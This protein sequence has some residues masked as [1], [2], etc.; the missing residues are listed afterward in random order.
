MG[1]NSR[2]A[3]MD[4]HTIYIFRN[5]SS[6]NVWGNRLSICWLYSCTSWLSTMSAEEIHVRRVGSTVDWKTKRIALRHVIAWHI[7]RVITYYWLM[8]VLT[9]KC[10][11]VQTDIGLA[12]LADPFVCYWIWKAKRIQLSNGD[13]LSS[14]WSSLICP[15]I[16]VGSRAMLI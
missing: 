9:K 3:P 11:L 10:V 16:I 1:T 12:R 6:T 2:F 5:V 4:P 13:W 15:I 7:V 8:Y 14:E